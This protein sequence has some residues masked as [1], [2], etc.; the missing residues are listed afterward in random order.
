[1]RSITLGIIIVIALSVAHGRAGGTSMEARIILGAVDGIFVLEH[2]GSFTNY[3]PG[4]PDVVNR[5][6]MGRYVYEQAPAPRT[7]TTTTPTPTPAPTPQASRAETLR[8]GWWVFEST[9]AGDAHA[10]IRSSRYVGSLHYGMTIRIACNAGVLSVAVGVDRDGKVWLL[11][12]VNTTGSYWASEVGSGK[13]GQVLANVSI[14]RPRD[15]VR[16]WWNITADYRWALA[17]NPQA[18]ADSLRGGHSLAIGLALYP[19]QGSA[20][21]PSRGDVPLAGIDDVLSRLSCVR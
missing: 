17:P 14:N 16:A 10:T 2:D 7:R 9:A 15:G 11:D 4:A 21:P 20:F 12:S 3:V 19:K 13:S 8:F 5:T 1:M 6:F 18:L